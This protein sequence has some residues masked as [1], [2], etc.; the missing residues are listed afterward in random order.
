M[1]ICGK[2]WETEGIDEEMDDCLI[3]IWLISM[4]GWAELD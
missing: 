4:H 1:R 2:M 3:G